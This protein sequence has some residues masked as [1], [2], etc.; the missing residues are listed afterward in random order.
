VVQKSAP[1]WRRFSKIRWMSCSCGEA[2]ILSS[3]AGLVPANVRPQVKR[4]L[5][6]SSTR[7]ITFWN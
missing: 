6:A 4:N 3:P 7:A 5:R 2:V 1:N